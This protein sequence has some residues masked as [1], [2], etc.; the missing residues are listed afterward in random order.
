MNIKYTYDDLRMSKSW[1]DFHF[2]VNY[3]FN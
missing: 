3:P 1:A 2:W